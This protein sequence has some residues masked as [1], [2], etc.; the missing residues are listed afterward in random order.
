MYWLFYNVVFVV[1]FMLVLPRYLWRMCRRGGYARG[2]TQRFGCY[3]E[4]LL[5]TL[6]ARK[7]IWVHAVSVGEVF[8]ALR[9]IETYRGA[10]P[11]MAFVLTT[12]T[13]TGH[14]IAEARLHADDV[15]LY[16]PVDLP[17]FIKRVLDRIQPAALV[18]TECELWPNLIH[19]ADERGIPIALLNGR[20]SDSSYRGYSLC[21]PLFRNLLQRFSVVLVQ[22][23]QDT[24]RVTELGAR[25]E[26]MHELGTAKYDV[27][28]TDTSKVELIRGVLASAGFPGD[29]PI[30]VG[31]STWPGEERVLLDVFQRL[32]RS[33]EGLKLV[34][35]PRHFERAADV[36]RELKTEGVSYV[37]R[38]ALE[39]GTSAGE[40]ADVLL[41]DSTGELMGVY[42]HASVIFV[43]KSLT[44]HGG[45]N[46]MEPALLGKPVLFGPNM[47]NFPVVSEDFLAADAAVQV[48][49]ESEL[50]SRL[51]KL[52]T[53][54]EDAATLGARAAELVRS[55]R[56]CLKRSVALIHAMQ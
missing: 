43:G 45:Q 53:D 47:E 16:F 29:A 3:D 55:K 49:N 46:I 52:L 56:G 17:L 18:L 11:D 35:V 6:K 38:S 41:V 8:V 39:P 44:N 7:R 2:F 25:P 10:H 32:R 26:R 9:F 30:I 51:G 54:A 1:G 28:T 23:K 42:A 22:G 5:T 14:R 21:R 24:A 19:L 15:L 50:E 27:A 33:I 20:V 4:A 34:L 48:A 31:G 12:N 40:P 36:E 37:K 13:S